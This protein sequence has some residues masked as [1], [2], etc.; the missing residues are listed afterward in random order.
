MAVAW[1]SVFHKHLVLF[2]TAETP[3][4][5]YVGV[6][7]QV[8]NYTTLTERVLQYFLGDRVNRTKDKCTKVSRSS[9]KTCP[10]G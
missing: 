5:F 8:N 3:Y 1:A 7:F 10:N 2:I 9:T 4:Q 6:N